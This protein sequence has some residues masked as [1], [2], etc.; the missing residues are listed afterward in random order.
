MDEASAAKLCRQFPPLLMSDPYT[1]RSKLSALSE[2]LGL[3]EAIAAKLCR[4]HPRLL[5]L[6]PDS[7]R[8]KLSELSDALRPLGVDAR[9]AVLSQRSLLNF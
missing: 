4:R 6:H 2:L 1:L 8:S 9:A 5:T 3:D 7:L